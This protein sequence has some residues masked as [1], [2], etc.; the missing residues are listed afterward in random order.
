MVLDFLGLTHLTSITLS[1]YIHAV[2]NDRIFF[3]SKEFYWSIVDL[4]CCVSFR[5]VEE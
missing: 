3:F 1:R 5:H 2:K 4:Q